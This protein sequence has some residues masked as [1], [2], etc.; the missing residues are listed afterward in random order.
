MSIPSHP[1]PW[2]HRILGHFPGCPPVPLTHAN[3]SQC[4]S[5]D[6]ELSKTR[7]IYNELSLSLYANI[8]CGCAEY[9]EYCYTN[10]KSPP[11][12]CPHTPP[13]SC[14]P[15]WVARSCVVG[16]EV[17]S[18][19]TTA[20]RRWRRS[21]RYPWSQRCQHPIHCPGN[22]G[23]SMGNDL[24]V[25]SPVYRHLIHNY[26]ILLKKSQFN[27]RYQHYTGCKPYIYRHY[28]PKLC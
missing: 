21:G 16:A 13:R 15:S 2:S 9:P 25:T 17:Y 20:W 18:I 5:H 6:D 12:P 1:I 26:Y 27:T 11:V 8:P 14:C 7:N 24:V 28:H 3:V 10:W 22:L 19:Q 23:H 4:P